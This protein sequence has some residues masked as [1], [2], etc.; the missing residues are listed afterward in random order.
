MG[1]LSIY[2]PEF[3]ILL[4]DGGVSKTKNSH[5]RTR[6]AYIFKNKTEDIKKKRET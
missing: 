4:K 5:I 6:Y 2:I 3:P 1:K